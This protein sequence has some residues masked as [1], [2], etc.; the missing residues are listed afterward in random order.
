MNEAALQDPAA[1]AAFV[2]PMTEAQRRVD[3]LQEAIARKLR[4]APTRLTHRFTPGLYIRELFVPAGSLVVTKIHKTEHPYVVSQ[5]RAAVWI[6]GR[7]VVEIRA[8]FTGVTKPGTRRVVFAYE[9]LVWTTFHP[10]NL[11]AVDAIEREIILDPKGEE[12]CD[13]QTEPVK[14]MEEKV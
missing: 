1:P 7:G 8:P 14:T 9:D 4:P 10:T 13:A 6:E 12:I 2:F 5:G 3:Q 11:T